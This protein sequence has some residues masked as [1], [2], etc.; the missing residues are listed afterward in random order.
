M[1]LAVDRWPLDRHAILI[2]VIAA[3]G[4]SANLL[5]GLSSY[6]GG[7]AASA[8]TFMLHGDAPYRDFW[9]LYGPGAPT[10]VAIA[11][12]VVGPSILV[13]RLLGLAA[14]GLQAAAAFAY[15]RPN[16]PHALAALI[17]IGATNLAAL[18]LGLDVTAWGVAL[19]LALLALLFRVHGTKYSLL[20]GVLIGLA[21]V[22]RLD[23][24]GY[25]LCAALLVSHRR[26]VL[27]GFAIIA[28]PIALAALLMTP[29]SMLYDQLIWYPIVGPRQFRGLPLP[30]VEGVGSL[31]VLVATTFVPKVVVG[32]AVIRLMASRTSWQSIGMMTV[33]AGLCQLQ[34]LGRADI[35]HQAQ[36]AVPAYVLLGVL[37]GSS[38]TP[39]PAQAAWQT[40]VRLFVVAAASVTCGLALVLGALSWARIQLG[41]LTTADQGLVAGIR[42]L[43]ASTSEG[44]AVFVGLT[45]H[46]ITFVNDTLAYYLAQRPAGVHVSMFNPGVTNTDSVQRRMVADLEASGTAVMLVNDRWARISEPT[47]DSSTLGS[48]ILDAYIAREF[49]GACDFGDVRVLARP[50][51]IDRIVCSDVV[52][53]SLADILPGLRDD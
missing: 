27:I 43:K 3:V 7:L 2:G 17:S 12:V 9:W 19:A 29:L 13:L 15:V 21:F 4:A 33:F 49:E 10:L 37:A 44:E 5:A 1:A 51:R 28:A 36:A 31:A 14:L 38:M 46:R 20:A 52:S 18:A 34:T 41:P 22:C 11:T 32:L 23:V 16:S 24:G 8:A 53:E 50:D 6:D 26:R 48:T 45:D 35:Y 47:N 40:M 25:A 30:V 42:T 39:R